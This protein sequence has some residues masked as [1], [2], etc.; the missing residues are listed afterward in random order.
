M[1]LLSITRFLDLLPLWCLLE[2]KY[3][4]LTITVTVDAKL[5]NG[6]LAFVAYKKQALIYSFSHLSIPESCGF[7]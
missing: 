4:M 6:F 1:F 7:E 3:N 2:S 5:I